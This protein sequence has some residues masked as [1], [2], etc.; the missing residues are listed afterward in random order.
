MCMSLHHLLSSTHFTSHV[1]CLHSLP[2]A[3]VM[4]FY[5]VSVLF[6]DHVWSL[7]DASGTTMWDTTGLKSWAGQ[8]HCRVMHTPG[9]QTVG[10]SA[11]ACRRV[12]CGLLGEA[13]MLLM[14]AQVHLLTKSRCGK[15]KAAASGSLVKQTR[16][17]MMRA[18]VAEAT[19]T[20]S[21]CRVLFRVQCRSPS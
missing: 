1:D 4:L 3:A 20:F 12:C 18:Q 6:G 7:A 9:M 11:L 14:Q 17:W 13:Y 16:G 21:H 5:S 19:V 15:L 10:G 2:W 8:R